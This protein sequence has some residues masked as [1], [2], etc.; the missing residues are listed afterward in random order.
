M[1][2]ENRMKAA[3]EMLSRPGAKNDKQI[4]AHPYV[5]EF[6][7]EQKIAPESTYE[8]LKKAIGEDKPQPKK[9]KK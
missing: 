6:L 2:K 1:T 8:Q 7:A 5:V 3:A 9:G 4:L